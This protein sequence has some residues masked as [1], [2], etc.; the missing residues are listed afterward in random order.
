M[1]HYSPS[2]AGFYHSDIH[3]DMPPDAAPISQQLHEE[4]LAAQGEGMVIL[5]DENGQ[6][7]A[8]P[9]SFSEAELL[10]QLRA[11]R[12]RLL[13]ESDFTQVADAPLSPAEKQAWAVYRQQLRDLPETIT[14][15]ADIAWPEPPTGEEP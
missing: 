3:A 14:N 10:A 4:L 2:T 13:S 5:T 8:A 15:P 11:K 12:D 6:P 1:L 7:Y 9:R